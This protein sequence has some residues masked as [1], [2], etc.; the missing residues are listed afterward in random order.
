MCGFTDY[1][2]KYATYPPKGILPLPPQAYNGIPNYANITDYC[3][4][5]D[6]IFLAATAVNP[7]F[8]IYRIFDL[9][10]VPWDVLGFPSSFMNTQVNIPF[11]AVLLELS[12]A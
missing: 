6:D 8:N 3:A 2:R 12:Q 4:L 10:P 9:W 5:W 1:S 7:N 11:C